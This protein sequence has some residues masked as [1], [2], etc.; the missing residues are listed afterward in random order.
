VFVAGSNI[1]NAVNRIGYSGVMNSPFF[2]RPTAAMP[3]RRVDV[4]L[5]VGF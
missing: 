3:G 5:R 2:G 1:F 4:G